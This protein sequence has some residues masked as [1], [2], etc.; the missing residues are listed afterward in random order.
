MCFSLALKD[1]TAA[2]CG[3]IIV[4]A[5]ASAT[6]TSRIALLASKFTIPHVS[7][8]RGRITAVKV[9]ISRIRTD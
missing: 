8:R 6:G 7:T 1:T 2:D 4:S 9:C 3:L 5:K